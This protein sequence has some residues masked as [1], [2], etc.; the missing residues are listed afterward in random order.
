MRYDV[1]V[2]GA[3]PVGSAVARDTARAGLQVL[4]L[5]EHREIGRPLQCSGF[6]TPRTLDEVGEGAETLVMNSVKGAIV[7]GPA[8]TKLALG[9]DRVRAMVLDRVGLDRLMAEGAERAGARLQL[10]TRL[11]GIER[12]NGHLEL[13]LSQGPGARRSTLEGSLLVGADGRNSTVARWMGLP[14]PPLIPAVSIDGE[15]AGHPQDMTQVFVG[16]RVAPGWFAWTIPLGEGRVRI[17]MGCD[18][19]HTPLKPRQLLDDLLAHFPE[20]FQGLRPLSFSGGFITLYQRREPPVPTTMDHAMVVGDAAGQVKPTSG[21][22]IYTG[23]LAARHAAGTAI[24]ALERGDLS[25]AALAPYE[26]GCEVTAIDLTPRAVELT[27][28]RLSPRGLT[29]DVRVG[30]TEQMEFEA[31]QFDFV[32]SWGVVHHSAAPERVV[33]EVHRVLKPLGE[34][35]LMVYHRRS[36]NAWT[37]LVRGILSGKLVKGMSFADMLSYY[38]DGY[39]ARYYTRDEL[40]A[41]LKRSGLATVWMYVL[42]QKSELLPLPGKGPGTALKSALLSAFPNRAAEGILSRWGSFLFAVAAKPG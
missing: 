15:L 30:D 27:R 19:S 37:A 23:L 28:K 36:L 20:E 8:G 41:M 26:A 4:L 35:R 6:V 39:V 10:A 9:G 1:V 11:V 38:T 13:M 2:V 17:G 24:A 12:V 18:P 42:G 16:N 34:L 29:A 5:E 32:W 7:H 14:R 31:G 21:G 40:A 22:G 25:S 3:G 33:Q